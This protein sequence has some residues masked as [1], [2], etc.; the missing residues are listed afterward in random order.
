M[1]DASTARNR[2]IEIV[3]V[4][5]FS[6]GAETK[7]VSGRSTTYYFNMKASMLDPE[8][9]HLMATLIL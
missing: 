9:A 8:A 4:R 1:T 5:S 2:L 6:T 7:L 3:R